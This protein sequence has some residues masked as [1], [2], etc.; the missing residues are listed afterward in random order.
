M[1]VS[2]DHSSDSWSDMSHHSIVPVQVNQPSSVVD[3]YVLPVK[4]EA[5]YLE[6]E[7]LADHNIHRSGVSLYGRDPAL[8]TLRPSGIHGA[9]SLLTQVWTISAFYASFISFHKV[10][11]G[12]TTFQMIYYFILNKLV[13]APFSHVYCT[14]NLLLLLDTQL[15]G[16]SIKKN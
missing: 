8:S 14:L 13:Y 15:C 9:S 12:R 4:R 6:R 11:A 7:P 1:M 5:L 3:E 2:Q 10:F 16:N